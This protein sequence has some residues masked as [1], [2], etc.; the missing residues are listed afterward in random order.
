MVPEQKTLTNKPS[1]INKT[2]IKY[3]KAYPCLQ[4]L[5]L[6]LE[7]VFSTNFVLLKVGGKLGG[8]CYL[9]SVLTAQMYLRKL[10]ILY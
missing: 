4:T 7:R 10:N 2:I 8:D 6:Y 9:I 3:N 1:P 5:L